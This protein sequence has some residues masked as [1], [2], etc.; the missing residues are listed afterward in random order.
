MQLDNLHEAAGELRGRLTE[1]G[2]WV[3]QLHDDMVAQAAD[4]SSKLLEGV[5]AT[6]ADMGQVRAWLGLWPTGCTP[7]DAFF[8]RKKAPQASSP[9]ASPASL[10]S[11]QRACSGASPCKRSPGLLTRRGA[12]WSSPPDPQEALNDPE[13][14]MVEALS[15]LSTLEAKLSAMEAEAKQ[16]S[17]Y[18]KLMD[19]PQVRARVCVCAQG[20]A[21]GEGKGVCVRSGTCCR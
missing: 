14:D 12:R 3:Q 2:E 1:M 8:P 6:L 10:L 5:M 18:Q 11:A 4:T 20:R 9:Q 16:L 17:S 7:A 13:T 15:T 19:V 21:A